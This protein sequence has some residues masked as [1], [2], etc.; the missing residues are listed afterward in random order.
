MAEGTAY[1]LSRHDG[2]K[3]ISMLNEIADVYVPAYQEPP[4][5]PHSMF[6]RESFLERT[7]RQA[8][9]DG[10]QLVAARTIENRLVGFS[11]GLPFESSR[12]WRDVSGSTPPPEIVTASKFAVIELVVESSHRGQGLAR[13]LLDSLLE[14]RAEKY[15]MLLAEPGTRARDMYARWGWEQVAQ[16]QS[17]PGAEIDDVLVQRL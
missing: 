4:Y 11:F 13:R 5:E 16:V 1:T 3:T 14:G 7:A 2:Q 17:Q 8:S 15:A 6:S 10:F 9:R 12:W